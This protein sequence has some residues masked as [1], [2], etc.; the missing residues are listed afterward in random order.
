M[1]HTL[2]KVHYSYGLAYLGRTKQ[3][4]QRRLHGHF[5]KKRLHRELDINAVTL[6]EKA[7]LPTEADMLLYE[8]YLINQLK[9][10]LN[11]ANKTRDELTVEL[12]PLEFKPYHCR[13]MDKWKA[14]LI[15]RDKAEEQE[16]LNKIKLFEKQ[17]ELRRKRN[18]GELTEDE[19][20]DLLEALENG[21]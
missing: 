12:P 6:I 18:A 8:L 10:P 17:Q 19:Y 7:D 11:Q 21:S 2:Y 4:L 3:P 1:A 13:L 15:E 16:R 5:F 14:Q 9:P 20:W